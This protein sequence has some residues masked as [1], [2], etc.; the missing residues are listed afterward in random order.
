MF[1]VIPLLPFDRRIRFSI[2][3]PL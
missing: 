1:K 2:S 3:L